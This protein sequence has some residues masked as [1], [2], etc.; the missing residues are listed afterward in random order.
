[1]AI[2][3]MK[4]L[5]LAAMEADRPALLSGLQRLGCVEISEQQATPEALAFAHSGGSD[6]DRVKADADLVKNAISVL[7]TYAPIKTPLFHS[8]E[9]ID[10]QTL[11][12][13]STL[14]SALN[15]ADRIRTGAASVTALTNQIA[16]L[17][18][19]QAT[20][21]PWL[22]AELPLNSTGT[23]TTLVRFGTLPATADMAQVIAALDASDA[24]AE[25][26]EISTDRELH[27]V[28]L[29]AHRACADD[30]F[31]ALKPFGFSNVVFKDMTG[32]PREASAAIDAELAACNQELE[33]V[34]QRIVEY[35]SE[36]TAL[37]RAA[38]R[39]TQDL[40][41][42]E[43]RQKFLV[44]D[45]VFFLTGWVLADK[46]PALEALLEK[47]DCALELRDP[48]EDEI[49]AVPVKLRN[50]WFSR[51]LNMVTEMY[52]L[53]A[54]NGVDPNPLMA[55]FFIFFYGFMMADMGYG[56]LMM[57]A[58]LIIMKKAKLKGPTVRHMV[59][60]LG[61]C[62]V[63]TFIMGALTG[64]FFGN[65]LPQ[66]AMLINPDTTFTE[67]PALFTPT[68]DALAVLIGSLALGVIQ[69]FTGMGISMYKQIK[70]GQ[71]MAALCNEGAWYLVFILF[72][73]GI[74]TGHLK[75]ALIA[76]V[77][78]LVLTQGYG[79]KGILGKLMGIFGSLYNN[80][81][82]YFSDILSY[83]RLMALMLAGAVI[84][85]VF[86]TLGG[87]TGNVITFFL[88]AMIGN[89][90]NFALNL[91][92]CFVHDMRLQCLEFFNRFYEDGGKPFRPLS[93][94]T[95]YVD[96]IEE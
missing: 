96:I 85:Q 6:L 2:E 43:T 83:S 31:A 23:A 36:R 92:S 32:T 71:V 90:L 44:T 77:V 59:P 45:S 38:D 10:E 66:L 76:I 94:N 60:L 35:G 37:Q 49:P 4:H 47:Y 79:K 54:Y 14:Y 88:I 33:E 51:P 29:L 27:Y 58:S 62:G 61:L 12:D 9:E 1:M 18:A 68:G 81:T 46:V 84:A 75:P 64:G 7:D 3:K 16:K 24:A 42:E 30:A 22:A 73:V 55:P 5:Q 82:G 95:K 52:S 40:A 69:I 13:D 93:F 80:I 74:L 70:R 91:L 21:Q 34:K 72:A 11:F 28:L 19:S 39:L 89:A 26:M 87:I 63:T 78:L 53:P 56:I 50:N 48:E 57:L 20:L 41:K 15:T 25:L 17:Q 86:N 8:G 67:M 65:L